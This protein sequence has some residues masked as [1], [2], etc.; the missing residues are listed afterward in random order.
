[1]EDYL[2]NQI[3]WWKTKKMFLHKKKQKMC[4]PFWRQSSNG[5]KRTIVPKRPCLSPWP[6]WSY[7]HASV[8][9]FGQGQ[10]INSVAGFTLL[11]FS[12]FKLRW[13]HGSFFPRQ[14]H[15]EMAA[16]SFWGIG[17]HA[18]GFFLFFLSWAWWATGL[19]CTVAVMITLWWP[20]KGFSLLM[21]IF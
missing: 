19:Y 3:V 16:S 13:R 2:G 8:L 15:S 1:M 9:F 10:R 7:T 17:R 14:K 5:F 4:L 11:H 21:V 20:K 6:L 18:Q 12:L